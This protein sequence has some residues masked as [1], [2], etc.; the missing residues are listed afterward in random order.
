VSEKTETISC[1]ADDQAGVILHTFQEA[2]DWSKTHAGRNFVQCES[3][4]G[5]RPMSAAEATKVGESWH[6]SEEIFVD[7]NEMS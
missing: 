2:C 1:D 3:G 5:Y 7:K 6:D 4:E